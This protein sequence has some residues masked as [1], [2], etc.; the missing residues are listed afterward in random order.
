MNPQMFDPIL[1]KYLA[2]PICKSDLELITNKIHCRNNKCKAEYFI[3]DGIPILLP[4]RKMSKWANG[5]QKFFDDLVKNKKNTDNLELSKIDKFFDHDSDNRIKQFISIWLELIQPS[6]L[7]LD[8]GCGCGTYTQLMASVKK[9]IIIIGMD[10]SFENVKKASNIDYKSNIDSNNKVYFIVADMNIMPF[11]PNSFHAISA[12]NILHH[13]HRPQKA[14]HELSKYLIK[15]GYILNI[16]I[17]SNNPLSNISRKLFTIMPAYVKKTMVTDLVV[18]GKIPEIKILR[19]ETFEKYLLA[20]DL[21]VVKTESY[22]L[23]LFILSYISK[24]IPIINQVISYKHILYIY[25]IEQKIISSIFFR[26]FCV[27]VMYISKKG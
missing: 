9:N 13:L 8:C 16:E 14:L 18:D 7:L 24:V 23:F 19:G 27:V 15:N 3:I 25:K 4:P 6:S 26:K 11:R 12:I 17:T 10:I 22:N 1:L 5:Q 20:S 21:K 2:C